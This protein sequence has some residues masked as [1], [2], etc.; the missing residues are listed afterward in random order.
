MKRLFSII[1]M[2]C[3]V[4]VAIVFADVRYFI[5]KTEVPADFWLLVPD[6]VRNLVAESDMDSVVVKSI[7]LRINYVLDSITEPGKFKIAVRPQ[8]ELEAILK[9]LAARTAKKE[10]DVLKLR[11]GDM[12]PQFSVIE[13]NGGSMKD[14]IPV[15]GK[16][17]LLTFWATWCGNCLKELQ[18]D[19]V[20][21]VAHSYAENRDFRF[22]PI[23][24]DTDSEMLAQFFTTERG[25]RW[26]FLQPITLIDVERRANSLFARAGV[27]PLNVV[28]GRDGRI[29][30]I[31]TGALTDSIGLGKLSEAIKAGLE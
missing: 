6:S 29:K 28:V 7:E 30:Y 12:A 21:A 18:P 23:C 1:F 9:M 2:S 19:F 16:C 8:E 15:P 17:Y 4:M 31:H 5:G 13:N 11:V 26:S 20:P 3:T 22:V 24:I 10:D 14:G 25:S 27:M